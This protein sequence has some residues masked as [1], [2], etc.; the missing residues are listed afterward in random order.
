MSAMKK[1]NVSTIYSETTPEL[2]ARMPR[3][4]RPSGSAQYDPV[5]YVPAIIDRLLEGE[6]LAMICHDK[7]MPSLRTVVRWMA[8]S[9][10]IRTEINIAKEEGMWAL[11]SLAMLISRG[12]KPYSTGCIRRDQM[13]INQLFWVFDKRDAKTLKS[14]PSINIVLDTKGHW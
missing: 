9:E 7:A 11:A 6:S 12:E 3:Q 10:Y 1:K 13:L 14:K 8:Q 2:V 4:G 5:E